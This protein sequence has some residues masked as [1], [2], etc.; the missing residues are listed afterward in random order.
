[1]TPFPEYFL[2][3]RA[4]MILLCP[5][6][7][8]GRYLGF[9]SLVKECTVY[10]NGFQEPVAEQAAGK[11]SNAFVQIQP[12]QEFFYLFLRVCTVNI[13]PPGDLLSYQQT[14]ITG[15]KY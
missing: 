5:F 15:E 7:N 9:Q 8:F 3:G 10:F 14:P 2:A 12:L 4:K 11:R 13:N 1:M 6:E